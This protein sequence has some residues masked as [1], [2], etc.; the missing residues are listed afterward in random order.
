VAFSDKIAESLSALLTT[1]LPELNAT[2]DALVAAGLRSQVKVLV[3]GAPVTSEYA[4]R[5]NADA[6]ATD[7]FGANE[8]V[9]DLVNNR[10]GLYGV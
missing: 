1:T 2:L 8:A 6:Y 5:I 4:G 7:L 9:S 10:I 3:G